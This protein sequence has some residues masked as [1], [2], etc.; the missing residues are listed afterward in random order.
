MRLRIHLAVVA[1]E[2]VEEAWGSHAATRRDR[3]RRVNSK[4]FLMQ[5]RSETTELIL[6]GCYFDFLRLVVFVGVD[7]FGKDALFLEL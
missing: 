6:L 2:L 3:V 7:F 5:N 1:D 4:S